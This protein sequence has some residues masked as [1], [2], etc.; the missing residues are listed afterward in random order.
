MAVGFLTNGNIVISGTVDDNNSSVA[1]LNNG[2]TF[3]GTAT[4]VSAYP[5]VVFAVKTDT[6]GL[7]YVDFSPDGTNWDSTLTFK[8]A[9]NTN[10][11]HR[12]TVTRKYFRIRVFNNSGSN[13]TYL[14]LQSML[15]SQQ[16]LTSPLNGTIQAD[17]DATLVRPLDFNLMVG[18]GLYQNRTNFIKDGLNS[19]IDAAST[20]EDVTNEGGVYAGFPT[21]TPE[22]G[23]IVVAG[24]D[25]GTV[26]F[27]YL[28]SAT[29]TDYTFGSVAVAGAGNYS[30]GVTIYRCN[31]A[32]FVSTNPTSFNV[33]NITIR[34]TT[35]TANVFCVIEA[36]F[37]QSFCAA[38]TVPFG[39]AIYLDRISGGLRGTNS[40]SLDGYFWYRAFGESPRLRFPF[41]LQ[42][43]GLYFDDVDYLIKIPQQVDIIPRIVASSANNLT[44]KLSYRFIKVIE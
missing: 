10:E 18:E 2:A 14:R 7:A 24:A 28:E 25:T 36:G 33:G 44:A 20:P 41:E 34:H 26:F 15:G 4:E 19:D 22:I 21:G 11:V 31:F 17:A 37:G 9:A 43:G 32:Y 1:P 5:S 29:S 6:T 40:G 13:Q 8:I 23:Q 42:Y 3:T 35:T 39:S 38:Y 12:I 27:F 16:S 30:T